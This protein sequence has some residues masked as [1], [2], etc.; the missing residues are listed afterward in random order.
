MQLPLILLNNARRSLKGASLQ[1][2]AGRLQRASRRSTKNPP[3]KW[4]TSRFRNVKLFRHDPQQKCICPSFCTG[5]GGLTDIHTC[6]PKMS[7]IKKKK[8]K[9]RRDSR[10]ED[11]PPPCSFP[12]SLYK[13]QPG[14]WERAQ[15]MKHNPRK[16]RRQPKGSANRRAPFAGPCGQS[17]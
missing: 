14:D 6:A 5:L 2:D 8:K 9:P 3:K 1:M 17:T 11:A 16:Y 7:T 10:K 12:S 4:E 15:S 13:E